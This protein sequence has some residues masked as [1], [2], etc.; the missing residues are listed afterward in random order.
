MTTTTTTSRPGTTRP[1]PVRAIARWAGAAYLAMFGLAIFANFAVLDALV[2]EGDATA[3]AAAVGERLGSFRLAVGALLVIVLLDLVIA[4][5]LDVVFR[6]TDPALS[7]AAAWLRV[8]YSAM[9]GVAVGLLA[10][11]PRLLDAGSDIEVLAA[12]DSFNDVW[13]VGLAVFG[14]H[15]VVLGI[16]VARSGLVPPALGWVVGLAGAAYLA[17]TMAQLL[18]ADYAAIAGVALAVVAIPSMVGE[19]WLALWLLTSRRIA[20]P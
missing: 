17:D 19:G 1:A 6:R 20:N 18:V 2:V 5:A 9:L 8:A 11:V 7:R 16:L 10:S 12:I 13:L 14:L 4:W 3:T 15:L